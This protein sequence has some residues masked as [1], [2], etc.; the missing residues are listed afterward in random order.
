MKKNILKIAVVLGML[1][2]LSGCSVKE[3]ETGEVSSAGETTGSL[4]VADPG[5]TVVAV[6]S[7]NT[8]ADSDDTAVV[9]EDT[10][11]D[12]PGT[13][14]WSSEYPFIVYDNTV[15][16]GLDN[17]NQ[18]IPLAEGNLD[19]YYEGQTDW[20]YRLFEDA[21][22]LDTVSHFGYSPGWLDDIK[23]EL[24]L[25]HYNGKVFN[26]L[27]IGSENPVLF[28][29]KNMLDTT[30]AVYFD[31]LAEL[32]ADNDL[33]EETVF[34][35]E[36]WETDLEGD[37]VNETLIIASNAGSGEIKEGEYTF[38]VLRKIIDGKVESLFL[39]K[40]ITT[41]LPEDPTTR[42]VYQYKLCEIADLNADGI[43]ELL[44]KRQYHEGYLY[45]VYQLQDDLFDMVIANGIEI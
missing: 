34:I 26:G 30:A 45:Q 41:E 38:I 6:D 28:G 29:K 4:T 20:G 42:L 37:G 8:A 2:I 7:G 40:N 44:I 22:Y 1:L 24:L 11:S 16:G 21:Q 9:A 25:L 3:A 33:E 14:A 10:G 12:E 15:I 13:I 31:Y 23:D 36:I 18:L 43:C 19:L 17:D 35:Q 39:V 5:E 32:L 27:A